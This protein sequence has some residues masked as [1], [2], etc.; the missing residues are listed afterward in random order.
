MDKEID[1]IDKIFYNYFEKN[2][3]VPNIIS[4]SIKNNLFSTKKHNN[5]IELIKKIVITIVSFITIG[6]SIVFA[7]DIKNF[8]LNFFNNSRGID[9]AIENGYIEEIDMQY[10]ESNNT[11]IK[12]ENILMDDYNLS[13]TLL[14]KFENNIDINNVKELNIPDLLVTDNENRILYCKDKEVFYNYCNKNNFD[15]EF[16]NYNSNYINSGSNWY[17]KSKLYENNEIELI[18]N[19]YGNTYPKSKEVNVNFKKINILENVD[20]KN[21][22]ILGDWNINLSIPE[23]FYNREALVYKVKSCSDE[24]MKITEAVVYNT[25][26]KL[27]LNVQEKPVYL[28]TDS[29][30]VKKQKVAQRV[31]QR[32]E[33]IAKRNFSNIHIF[34]Y[35]PYV[36]TEKG[37]RYY[38]TESSSQ[39]SGFSRPYTGDITYWQ[40]FTLT[41]YDATDKL[42]IYIQYK[43]NNVK[44]ELERL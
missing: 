36:E 28:N 14:I 10:I 37:I 1:E 6:G 34:G 8:V 41:K 13:F 21:K 32:E 11:Q 44:I 26:M 18:Y 5:I 30:E 27:Q 7:K 43:Q 17:I 4:N 25:C 15:Y 29:E 12:I 35:D 38:P 9:T 42:T 40:T 39:D 33:D 31:K 2:K 22:V 3:E 24:N 20:N 23:Q 19:L 16:T